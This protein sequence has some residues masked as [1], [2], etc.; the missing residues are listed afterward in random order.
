MG[1]TSSNTVQGNFIGTDITGNA[2]LFNIGPG[3]K[4]SNGAADNLIGGDG[5][6][7][8]NLIAFNTNDGIKV[9]DPTTLG[10]S[11]VG[12]LIHDNTGRQID[13]NDDGKSANDANDP[14]TGPN[15]MQNYPVL[16]GA[17][18]SGGNIIVDGLLDT[19][20][21]STQFLIEFFGGPAGGADS[22]GNGGGNTLLGS[23]I[24]TT[25]GVGDGVFSGISIGA[26]G[27]LLRVGAY[28]HDIGKMLKPE[29]FIENM[30]AGTP[31]PHGNLAPAMSALTGD[32][33]G[34]DHASARC[35]LAPMASMV[36]TAFRASAGV[37]I[38]AGSRWR[39]KCSS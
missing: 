30:T 15:G 6:N 21:S 28:F 13:L 27:L 33:S 19:D 23:T 11:F 34:V 10:N 20:R 37:G 8:G 4:L 24:M 9:T 14:D 25:D 5:A 12:N 1:N 32:P 38:R 26:N 3:I 18:L 17:V 2:N 39:S 7:E 36:S 31:S 29:Y 22:S 35:W 16:T